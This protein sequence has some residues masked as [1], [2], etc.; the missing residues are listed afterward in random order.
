MSWRVVI[1]ASAQDDLR[2]LHEFLLDRELGRDGGDLELPDHAI[3]A[4]QDALRVLERHPYTCR[5]VSDSPFWR[6]LVIAA[7]RTG[8]VAQFEIASDELGIV[9]AIRHHR[10]DD[11][12]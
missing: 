10:E 5:K 1:T 3:D 12:H 7:G 2:R 8:Y 4:I 11:Y 6:E 9:G